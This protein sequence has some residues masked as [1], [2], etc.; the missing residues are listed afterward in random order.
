MVRAKDGDTFERLAGTV[1]LGR[2]GE[3]E[4]RLLNDMYP[5]GEP[6]AGQLLKII[7]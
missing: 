1:D 4:L 2:Y 5:D 7:E 3:E 6:E